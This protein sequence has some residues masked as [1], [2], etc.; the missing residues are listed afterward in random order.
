MIIASVPIINAQNTDKI[1]QEILSN[2]LEIKAESMNVKSSGY[3]LKA[4]N[5]LPDPEIEIGYNF[6]NKKGEKDKY[7]LAISQSFDWPGIY[8]A[9]NSANKLKMN[10]F[11]YLFDQKKMEL[12]LKAK[13]LCIDLININQQIK[14]QNDI[15]KNYENLFLNYQK[16]FKQGEIN[17]LDINK[18]KIEL[19]GTRSKLVSYQNQQKILKEDLN[20][21]NGGKPFDDNSIDAL[22]NY[23]EGKLLPLADYENQVKEI[24]PENK[25]YA[26]LSEASKKDIAVNKLGWF[27]SF[28]L[29]YKYSYEQGDKFNGFIAATS[30]PLFSNR[31]KTK[32]AEAKQ[33]ENVFL[34]D[35]AMSGKY[36]KLK[37]KYNKLITLGSN[38]EAYKGILNDGNNLGVLRKALDGG[39]ISLLNYLIEYKYFLDA[40]AELISMQYEYNQLLSEINKYNLLQKQIN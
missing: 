17:I 39:Q 32:M 10:A 38:I 35:N 16:G 25:Y 19:L 40:Q 29:G 5:N 1:L 14:M 18:L 34:Q 22:T 26:T 7:D 8:G 6:G 23:D 12:L 3:E 33:I 21:L 31:Y 37:G 20:Q 2:N 11:S 9:R 27:P 15:V 28:T 30:I 36:A 13:M 4:N 24:D